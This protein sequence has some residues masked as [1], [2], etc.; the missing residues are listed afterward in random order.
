M[1]GFDCSTS[2]WAGECVAAVAGVAAVA[3]I[4]AASE[5]WGQIL[6]CPIL[7]GAG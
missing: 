1:K 5:L 7:F 6:A 2:G 4:A 3:V